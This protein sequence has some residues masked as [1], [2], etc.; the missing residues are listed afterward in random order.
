MCEYL[1]I[2]NV[3]IFPRI[4]SYIRVNSVIFWPNRIGNRIQYMYTIHPKHNYSYTYTYTYTVITVYIVYCIVYG[5]SLTGNMARRSEA[6]LERCRLV[7]AL[8]A[9]E[10]KLEPLTA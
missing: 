3:I 4:L 9:L 8:E 2:N 5:W 10:L 1:P 7:A 6:L